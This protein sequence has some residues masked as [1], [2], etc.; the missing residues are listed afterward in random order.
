MNKLDVS[1]MFRK[2]A[3]G[4]SS[5]EGGDVFGR[6]RNRISGAGHYRISLIS[7]RRVDIMLHVMRARDRPH[8]IVH[9]AASTVRDRWGGTKTRFQEHVRTGL[10]AS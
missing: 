7:I 10:L 2:R 4:S 9:V 3:G 6:N 8:D 5:N 1:L